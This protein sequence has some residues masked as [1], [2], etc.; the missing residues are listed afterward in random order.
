MKEGGDK[1][2]VCY[3]LEKE[4]RDHGISLLSGEE[5]ID[6]SGVPALSLQS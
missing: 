1:F 5:E 6:Q 3:S 2:D 4:S